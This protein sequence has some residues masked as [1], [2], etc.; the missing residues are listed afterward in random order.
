M[1]ALLL[2]ILTAVMP[3]CTDETD[4]MCYWDAQSAGNGLGTSF[5]ALSE[6]V[7]YLD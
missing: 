4:T 1:T 2:A 5:I 3:A 6:T 7:I